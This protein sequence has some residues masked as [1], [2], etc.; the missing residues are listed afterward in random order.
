MTDYQDQFLEYVKTQLMGPPISESQTWPYQKN[1]GPEKNYIMGR[2]FPQGSVRRED[3]PEEQDRLASEESD[4]LALSFEIF[5]S[6]VGI[7]FLVEEGTE[8]NIEVGGA[9]YLLSEKSGEEEE[10]KW[11]RQ[12]YQE[13]ITINT[14]PGSERF[15]VLNNNA[16]LYVK[17][18][19][20]SAGILIT[21]TFN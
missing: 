2:L 6:S 15:S 12:S 7:S 16:E 1:Y 5:P 11:E 13:I 4:P 20:S 8:L 17:S 18:R 19:S 21:A 9:L 14:T 10:D 3:N